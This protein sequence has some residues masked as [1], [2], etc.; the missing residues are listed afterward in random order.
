MYHR[1][2]RMGHAAATVGD[3]VFMHGGCVVTDQTCF[4]KLVKLNLQTYHWSEVHTS[5]EAPPGVMG[6]SLT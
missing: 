2:G 1:I 5:G 6:H 4:K 3:V